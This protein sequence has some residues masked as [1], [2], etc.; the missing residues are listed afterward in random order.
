[1]T[2]IY[3]TVTLA[4]TLLLAV[5]TGV[6][7]LLNRL[8]GRPVLV[9][10][11]VVEVLLLGFAIGGVVQMLTADVTFP[12]WEALASL[13]ALVVVPPLGVAWAFDERSR[14]GTAVFAV[15]FLVV[16]VMIVRVQQVWAGA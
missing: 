6:L 7:A 3:A 14:S 1:M 11:G 15:V 4:A 5:W 2:G 10:A 16:A 8:P 9:A 12:R 13:A